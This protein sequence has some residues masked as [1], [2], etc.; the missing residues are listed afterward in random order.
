MACPAAARTAPA[1]SKI[2]FGIAASL[3]KAKFASDPDLDPLI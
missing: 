1:A 2:L 3:S